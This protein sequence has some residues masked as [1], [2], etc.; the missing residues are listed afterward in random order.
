[1]LLRRWLARSFAARTFGPVASRHARLTCEPLESREVPSVTLNSINDQSFPGGKDLLV[2]LTGVDSAGQ[3]ITYSAASSNSSIGVSVISAGTTI[4]LNVSGTKGDGTSFAGDIIIR[5]FDN[6][7]PNSVAHI[8][9]LVNSAFY[10]NNNFHRVIDNF[11]AQGGSANGDGTGNSPLGPM[12]D[13]FDAHTTFVSEGL[14]A[15]ANAGDD[16]ADSQFFITDTDL[17]LAQMAQHLNFNYTII[18]QLIG[19][20]D[21]F[22][23][24][25]ST[26]VTA[27]SP[28]NPE[29]SKPVNPVTINS[30]SVISDDHDA[31]LRISAPA[32]FSGTSNITI[33]ANTT[34][35]GSAQQ[36]F[37]VTSVV[38][39]IND[40]P[41]LGS[42]PNQTTTLG[43]AVTFDLPATDLESDSLT[44]VVTDP[45]N[46]G[47]T[48]ANVTISIDQAN[49]L[50]TVTPNA[51]FTGTINL[52]VGVRD[53]T[54][55]SGGFG[56]NAQSNF[57]T[58]H[59]TLT[60]SGQIDLDAA[61]DTGFYNDDNFTG[62]DTPSFT[63]LAPTGLNV[64]LS[65]NGSGSFA[66]TESSTPGVYNVTLPAGTLKVGA[67][68]IAGT[69][70]NP[71]QLQPPINFDPL[72]VTFAPSM[73][74]MFVV[75]GTPGSSQ[76]IAFALTSTESSFHDEVGYFIAD[77]L[78]G[79]I[80]ALAPGDAGY[81]EA[82]MNT[83]HV[84]LAPNQ[85]TGA[86]GSVTLQGG[87]VLAFYLIQNDTSA[88]FIANNVANSK[89]VSPVAFFSLGAANPDGVNHVQAVGDA[90]QGRVT[91]G[92]EDLTGGGDRDYNDMVVTIQA[93][94]VSGAPDQAIL[95]PASSSRDVTATF[96][97]QNAVKS[98]LNSTPTTT[99][100]AAGEFGF[101]FVDSPDGAI[102]NLHPGDPGY[103]QAALNARH[104]LFAFNDPAQTQKTLAIPGG[105]YI[106]F[107]LVP[108]SSAANLLTQNPTNAANGSPVA[109][110]SFSAANPDSGTVHFRT[111]SPEQVT[112]PAPTSNGPIF[113]HGMKTL[114][115]VSKDFDDLL[116]SLQFTATP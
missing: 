101:F 69:A 86:N 87:Q 5:L 82:A 76:Q 49:H 98:K 111:Y 31:V 38:D 71:Q 2:P 40:P 81:A 54:D 75:P 70:I 97:L 103:A 94:G 108:G 57:D 3:A 12:N 51:G 84:L 107:Y 17:S 90:T 11:M 55:R 61:S 78:Q 35:D 19:G 14:V 56:L 39:T 8:V 62:D 104:P 79:H 112:E 24:I 32:N 45:N 9:S 50:A 65:V 115:G 113:I 109:F 52:L 100:K 30:A 83:H 60:V 77:D 46:F 68:I 95:A 26:Q 27:Q 28:Q 93:A 15:L 47:T 33:T 114:N 99:T 25:M 16:T 64:T 48:P 23:D 22:A 21:I 73:T 106:G 102:G 7:A 92:W 44:Y 29:V 105:S 4:D 20:F 37:N 89:S 42:I 96:Q 34:S 58:Q 74:S 1:M 85:T 91:Y 80:G 67:N 10:T 43:T 63:I 116:V 53:Q 13:E 59:I 88:N 36:S 41:F 18:G 6:I 66:A 110:F 72:T